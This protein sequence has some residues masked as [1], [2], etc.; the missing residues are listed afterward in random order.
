[1]VMAAAI[2]LAS[3]DAWAQE[4]TRQELR[5]VFEQLLQD[6]TNS[7]LNFRYASLAR[8]RGELRKALAAYERI[9][10]TDPDNQEA[11]DGI[12]RVRRLLLE[13]DTTEIT[14]LIGGQYET[15][16]KHEVDSDSGTDDSVLVGRLQVTDK[17]RFGETRWRT[18]ADV[19]T[20]WHA[21]FGDIDFLSV[22]VRTGPVFELAE[23][24]DIR[25]AIG[26]SYAILDSE[27][28]LYEGSFSLSIESTE[29]GVFRSLNFRGA[30]NDIDSEIAGADAYVVEVNPRFVFPD[31]LTERDQAILNPVYRYNGVRGSGATGTGANADTFPLRYHVIGARADYFF[32]ITAET[33]GG[34]NLTANYE[35]YNERVFG[36]TNKRRDLYLVPGAQLI[37]SRVFHPRH[38]VV[39]G[40]QYERNL[41]NDD[42]EDY[43]NH[44]A[45]VRSVWRF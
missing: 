12:R 3:G 18:D 15:N 1:M 7:D 35:I 41:S 23:G 44:I 20:N 42:F 10:A 9:L 22:G 34:L 17:R 36:K 32:P 33:Y 43:E 38:D 27:P 31:M 13:P 29:G 24:W 37:M 30:Y 11:Q 4:P 16:P 19:F 45:R 5:R 28:F 21:K 6:P 39:I 40:Y 2:A 26:A 14:A 8:E 25:P